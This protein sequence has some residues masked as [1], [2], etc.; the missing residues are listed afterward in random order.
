ML[1][2]R[3]NRLTE[4]LKRFGLDAIAI[5]PGP[6]L[7]YLTGMPFHLMERPV[8]FLIMP[9]QEPLLIL[10][11]LEARKLEQAPYPIQAITYSDNPCH[12]AGLLSIR[13]PK[14]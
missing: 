7:N 10:P 1:L 11:N 14:H 12:L 6:T 2:E 9:P 4:G 5:N 3:M 13:Q 8:V